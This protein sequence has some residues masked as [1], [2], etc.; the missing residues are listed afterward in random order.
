MPGVVVSTCNR[1]LYLPEA[2]LF[3]KRLGNFTECYHDCPEFFWVLLYVLLGLS[4]FKSTFHTSIIGPKKR[5]QIWRCQRKL[6]H[7]GVISNSWDHTLWLRD[8]DDEPKALISN[9]CQVLLKS[10]PISSDSCLNQFVAK[11]KKDTLLPIVQTTFRC[12]LIL[13]ITSVFKCL[14]SFPPICIPVTFN[15][16]CFGYCHCYSELNWVMSFRESKSH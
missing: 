4:S 2:F 8:I 1:F 15:N 11:E 6:W 10:L 3:I 7:F 13:V 12:S 14:D 9:S 5:S 16:D